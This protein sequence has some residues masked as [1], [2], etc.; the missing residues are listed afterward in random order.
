MVVDGSTFLRRAQ[1]FYLE[2]KAGRR[3]NARSL[4]ELCGCSRN[5]AQRTIYRLRDEYFVPL[6]YDSS[7]KGYFLEDPHYQLPSLLPAGRDELTALLLARDML[8]TIDAAD[9]QRALDALWTH[10]AA[11]NGA[12]ARDLEPLAAV[13]SADTT[14]VGD[15]ADAGL[16]TFVG[17]AAAGENVQLTYRSPW[18]HAEDRTYTGRIQR[19]HLSDG[20]LYL[21][22]HEVSGREMILNCAFIKSFVVLDSPIDLK[23]VRDPAL[24]GA[25]NWLEGFGI[26][27]GSAPR[28]I[29]LAIAA[30][31]STYY[32][33]QRWHD[34]QVDRWEG[35]VLIRTFPGI[36]SPE[37]VRRVLSLGGFVRSIEPAELRT[38]VETEARALLAAIHAA[39]PPLTGN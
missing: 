13:F 29:V 8:A 11:G 17:A 7:E 20:S 34:D 4:A 35:D 39:A 36:V 5:T 31:A 22:F 1:R 27:A 10:L 33:A 38:A 2:L 25:D 21:K 32:S 37:L 18:R 23:P 9:L 28:D 3:P 26:W 6:A 24:K 12:V 15:I 16:L 14:V 19:V 30:P